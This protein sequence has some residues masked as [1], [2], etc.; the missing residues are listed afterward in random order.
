MLDITEA[1][2]VVVHASASKMYRLNTLGLQ[3]DRY[4]GQGAASDRFP[5]QICAICLL[6]LYR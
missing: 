2:A 6:M 1:L 3:M 4:Q 5:S